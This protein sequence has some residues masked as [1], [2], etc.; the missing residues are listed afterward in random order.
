MVVKSDPNTSIYSK[1]HKYKCSQSKF[2]AKLDVKKN[3]F[4]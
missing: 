3:G 1:G 4:F 2:I